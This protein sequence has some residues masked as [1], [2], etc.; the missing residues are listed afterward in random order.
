M[1]GKRIEIAYI[2]R[3]HG[4]RGEVSIQYFAQSPDL[5]KKPLWLQSPSAPPRQIHILG[6]REQQDSLLLRIEGITDRNAAENLRGCSLWVDA[7]QLPAP[8]EGEV[9]LHQLVGLPVYEQDGTEP[10]GKLERVYFNAGQEL[11]GIE[12]PEGREILFPALPQFVVSIDLEQG[13]I[14]ISPP[15]GLLELY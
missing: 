14:V 5:L 6:V 1:S 9:Y 4:I 11:W 13:R 10:L 2:G 15:A 8:Q 3:A 7:D 12:S